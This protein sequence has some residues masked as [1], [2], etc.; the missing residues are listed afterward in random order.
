MNVIL[1]KDIDLN[2]TQV[3]DRQYVEDALGLMIKYF[4]S[5]KNYDDKFIKLQ[6]NIFKSNDEECLHWYLSVAFPQKWINCWKVE[7]WERYTPM[8]CDKCTIEDQERVKDFLIGKFGKKV[9]DGD[10]ILMECLIKLRVSI[11][12]KKAKLKKK[13]SKKEV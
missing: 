13:N 6:D 8:I 9:K 1:D 5:K 7:D 4:G 10:D 12:G 2:S 11:K 3:Y